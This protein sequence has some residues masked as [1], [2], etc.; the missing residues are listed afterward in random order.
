MFNRNYITKESVPIDIQTCELTKSQIAKYWDAL[1]KIIDVVI[2]HGRQ[3]ISYQ[4]HKDDYKYYPK[5]GESSYDDNP[6][7]F[8]ETLNLVVRHGDK[9]LEDLVNTSPL[10]TH[11]T[12]APVQNELISLCDKYITDRI[13]D[14]IKVAK[15]FTILADEVVVSGKEQL[16][17]VIRFVDEGGVVREEFLKFI[18]CEER[19]SGVKLAEYILFSIKEFLHWIVEVKDMMVLLVCLGNMLGALPI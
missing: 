10:N 11:Y 9:V 17:L 7:N 16:A 6:G 13:V 14:E 3:G 5:V 1:E 2:Y 18:W 4:G 12:S 8:V 19:V 15:F